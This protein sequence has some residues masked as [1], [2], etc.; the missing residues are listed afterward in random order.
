MLNVKA[1]GEI[2]PQ[3]KWN[4]ESVFATRAD[5]KQAYEKVSAELPAALTKFQ[6]HLGDNA[7]AL[8][9]WF[10]VLDGIYQRVGHL[11]FYGLMS[12][13]VETTDQEANAMAGQSTGLMGKFQAAASFAEPELLAL[14]QPTLNDWIKSE[15][16]LSHYAHYVDDLF[17]RQQHVRSA[18][19][20]ELLGLAQDT[21]SQVE[22]TGEQLTNAEIVFRP[23]KN[24]QGEE[25]AISQGNFEALRQEADREIRRTA[26]ESYADGYLAFKNTLASNYTAS[27]KRD[28][29]LARARRF[30]TALEASLFENNIPPEVFYN[31]ID[32]YRKN[33]PTWHRYWEIRR[34][35]LGVEK[36]YPYDIWAPIAKQDHPVPYTQAVDWISAGMKPLGDE[37]VN[38]LR[39]GCLEQRWID[40][41]PNQGKR[42]G[43]F[44]FGWRG[45][46]PFILTSYHDELESMST[47]AHELGHSM[48]SYLTWQNQPFIYSDYSLFVAEVASNFNQAMV[49]GY[50]KDAQPDTDFQ[51]A[52]IEEA[53]NNFHRYFFIMPTLARFELEIHTRIEKEE[54][55]TADDMIALMADLFAE[56]YGDAMSYNREQ[57]GITWAQFGHLYSNYYVFQYATGISAAHALAAP[58]LAGT[59]GAA[60][61]Y[62]KFLKTGSS[63]Y[64]LDAL[65]LA[66][67]DMTTPAAVEATF[68]V[69]GEMVDRLEKLVG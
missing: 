59:P 21:F 31:L 24:S 7:A 12:Q 29:F 55:V 47:V 22:N 9:D 27:A 10:D 49:R 46:Y 56:G 53:M 1:R 11:L 17:R 28:I 15:P 43:A 4:A 54:G 61:N 36:L 35:A 62:L 38:T 20:E 8:A 34:K 51:I 50:L 13:A 26:W 18:E 19:V 23:A 67:V 69:L 16:R 45:T 60:D 65:K 25:I 42:Q 52:L 3:Y 63:L 68:K 2:E 44:S 5:W 66:G 57:S 37:Y 6:G 40:V 39:K 32:T 33:I 30:D 58:I 48:H 14:G 64:P 41:Y